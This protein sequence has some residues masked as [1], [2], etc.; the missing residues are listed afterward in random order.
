MSGHPA[1]QQLAPITDKTVLKDYVLFG[2]G[3]TRYRSL[4][5]QLRRQPD[6]RRHGHR[7]LDGR[8]ILQGPPGRQVQGL[9]RGA[10]RCCHPCLGSF[11]KPERRGYFVHFRLFE[12]A[13]P[14]SNIVPAPI[15][16]SAQ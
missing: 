1:S 14:V 16:P 11:T 12:I 4:G 2:M 5:N 3:L 6:T 15:P 10:V 8:A 7:Q 13:A 9:G